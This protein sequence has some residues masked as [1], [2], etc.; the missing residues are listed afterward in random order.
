[1]HRQPGPAYR[2]RMR[3]PPDTDIYRFAHGLL[4]KLGD[5]AA[6]EAAQHHADTL[7]QQGQLDGYTIWRQIVRTVENIQRMETKA[8]M[9][10]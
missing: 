10:A 1:M 3:L 6:L 4:R 8:D 2:D 9:A 7:L 5:V